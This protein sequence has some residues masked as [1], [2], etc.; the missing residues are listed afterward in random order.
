MKIKPEDVHKLRKAMLRIVELLREDN[1][2]YFI[3]TIPQWSLTKTIKLPVQALP[4][5]LQADLLAGNRY[6]VNANVGVENEED[7]MVSDFE[8]LTQTLMMG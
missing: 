7:L 1:V 3:A 4:D 8:L 2:L 5:N 6:I